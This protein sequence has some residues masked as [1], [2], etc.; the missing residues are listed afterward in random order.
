VRLVAARFPRRLVVRL[1]H[2]FG[3][4]LKKGF[5]YDLIHSNALHLTDRRDVFQPYDLAWLRRDLEA[6]LERGFDVVN[7]ATEPI[8]AADLAREVFG[9]DF[10]NECDREPRVYDMRTR[11]GPDYL[12]GRDELV[13][14]LRRFREMQ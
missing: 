11:H 14:A 4:G 5:V 6:F 12:Y 8:T 7:L 9:I 10:T 2:V 1:P 13:K 3:P